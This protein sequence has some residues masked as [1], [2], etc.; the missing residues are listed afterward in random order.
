MMDDDLKEL[1]KTLDA[2]IRE[3]GGLD[4]IS[5]ERLDKLVSYVDMKLQKPYDSAHHDRLIEHLEDSIR[6]FEVSYPDLTTVMNNML[7]MLSN[8]GI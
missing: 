1:K 2:Q 7:T 8:L 5:R 4:D 6:Y 3:M